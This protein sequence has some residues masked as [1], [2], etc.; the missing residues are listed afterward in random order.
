MVHDRGS[1]RINALQRTTQFTE[2]NALQVVEKASHESACDV[3]GEKIV[4]VAALEL[5]LS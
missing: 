4:A 3:V 2:L 5:G 1:P